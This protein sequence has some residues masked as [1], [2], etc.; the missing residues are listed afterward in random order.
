MTMITN[1]IENAK[2]VEISEYTKELIIYYAQLDEIW[3]GLKDLDRKFEEDSNGWE[4]VGTQSLE[5]DFTAFKNKFAVRVGSAMTTMLDW[6]KS[7]QL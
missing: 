2:N 1:Y 6:T 7:K 5:A 4:L 3:E